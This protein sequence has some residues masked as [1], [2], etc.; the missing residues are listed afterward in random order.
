MDCVTPIKDQGSCGSCASFATCAA[1]ESQRLIT[2]PD[3]DL[4]I[5]LSEAH[6]FFCNG[7]KC[8]SGATFEDIFSDARN[9]VTLEEY[10]PYSEY[11]GECSLR[12]GWDKHLTYLDEY[13]DVPNKSEH[14]MTNIVESGPLVAG[15][16]VYN[17]FYGYRA[18]IYRH[19]FG[20]FVGY[21]AVLIV[22]YGFEPKEGRFNKMFNLNT[23]YWI[24]K[25][26]W[27]AD[28]GES[29]FFRVKQGECDI[30]RLGVY[31]VSV[32]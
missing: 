31:S 6:L 5:D 22:G 14:I 27:G 19:A 20:D 24:V 1:L 17:D 11:N 23:K 32:R 10:F 7:Y 8:S 29:G 9:G 18:G 21:H 3:T 12:P 2:D 4:S 13:S 26:S 25:N 30:G 28:W 16:K 15:M